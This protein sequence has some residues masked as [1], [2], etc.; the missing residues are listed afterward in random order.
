MF[1]I[2]GMAAHLYILECADGSYYVGH[3]TGPLEARIAAHEQGAVAGYTKIRRPVRLLWAQEFATADE[4][5]QRERQV[6]GWSRAKK[7][8]LIEGDW[9]EISRLARN[10]HRKG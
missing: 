7:R 2:P 3:T 5:F 9:A 8:A 10:G 4:A 1:P 6:K